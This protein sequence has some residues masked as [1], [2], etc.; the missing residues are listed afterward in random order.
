MVSTDSETLALGGLCRIWQKRLRLRDWEIHVE[1]ARPGDMPESDAAGTVTYECAKRLAWISICDPACW[2]QSRR[3]SQDV[4]YTL[5]HELV[6]VVLAPLVTSASEVNGMLEEQSV[7]QLTR[8]LLVGF[9]W[10]EAGDA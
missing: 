9:K 5:V 4:E 8:A 1:F 10:K 2:P 6:H 7:D 3:A